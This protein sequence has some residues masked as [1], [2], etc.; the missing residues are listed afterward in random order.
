[1]RFYTL[2]LRDHPEMVAH[3]F[4]AKSNE[5]IE[6]IFGEM[7]SIYPAFQSAGLWLTDSFKEAE[8][9]RKHTKLWLVDSFKEAEYV[10]K[11]AVY[12]SCLDVEVCEIFIS[13]SL[14]EMLKK[15]LR[16]LFY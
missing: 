3:Y 14:T 7:P 4:A 2:R 10:R 12:L 13:F 1:M 6:L 5:D 15:K 9:V 11:R 16:Q 8:Y